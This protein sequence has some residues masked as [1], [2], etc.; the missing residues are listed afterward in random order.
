MAPAGGPPLHRRRYH[1]RDDNMQPCHLGVGLFVPDQ[2]E[3]DVRLA[4]LTPAIAGGRWL[5]RSE[6]PP[7]LHVGRIDKVVVVL[8]QP[9]FGDQRGVGK[10]LC[11]AGLGIIQIMPDR[12]ANGFE[13][14]AIGRDERQGKQLRQRRVWLAC[15]MGNEMP[16]RGCRGA[17]RTAAPI[18]VRIEQGTGKRQFQFAVAVVQQ[19]VDASLGD[20][21][22]GRPIPGRIEITVRPAALVRP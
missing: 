7:H 15:A 6:Y 13:V 16:E 21:M 20:V 18:P 5:T 17:H 10:G 1:A 12:I 14:V 11:P 19:R 9:G 2:I 22:I 3:I 8:D 4:P